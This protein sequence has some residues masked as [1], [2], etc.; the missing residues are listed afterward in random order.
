VPNRDEDDAMSAALINA[1]NR[2]ESSARQNRHGTDNNANKFTDDAAS[3]KHKSHVLAKYSEISDEELD[4]GDEAGATDNGMFHNT[5]SQDIDD[6]E[7]KVREL[8]QEVNAL[9]WIVSL[10]I[11]S[12]SVHCRHTR[13]NRRETRPMPAIKSRRTRT[14]RRKL[15]SEHRSKN[16][17]VSDMYS[18]VFSSA[19]I[20]CYQMMRT[21]IKYDGSILDR[22]K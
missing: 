16:G 11:E 3:K 21:G 12:L 6:R 8:Q 22:T 17:D 2:M 14:E 15:N 1:M 19:L 13:N 18:L 4:Y 20:C 9:A 7:K 5:N 10:S